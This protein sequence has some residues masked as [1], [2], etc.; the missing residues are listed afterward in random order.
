NYKKGSLII[1]KS[2][3]R[4][5]YDFNEIITQIANQYERELFASPT[6]FSDSGTDFGSHYVHLIHPPKIALV[7]GPGVNSLSY[8]V[9]WHFFEQQLHFPVASIS[10]E[11]LERIDLSVLDVLTLPC[12]HYGNVFKDSSKITQWLQQGG[13][14]IAI[15]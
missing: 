11:H 14:L 10:T 3:N 6:S 5:R 2:D 15:D 12:A 13:R 8:G 7:K 1:T 4:N 9:L